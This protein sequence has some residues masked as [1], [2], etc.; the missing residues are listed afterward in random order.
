MADFPEIPDVSQMSPEESSDRFGKAIAIAVVLATLAAALV[1]FLQAGALRTDDEAAVR[2]ERLAAESLGQRIRSQEIAQVQF[3]RFELAEQQRRRAGRARQRRFFGSGDEQALLLEEERLTRVVTQTE[4]SSAAIAKAQ[5]VKPLTDRGETG[6]Q[7][8]PLFP[9][10]YLAGARREGYRL[11]ALRD[12]ANA[13]GDRAEVQ[14]TNY[15][16]SLTM[17]AVAV[18][19][20]GYSLTPQG[21]A[22][23]KLFAGVATGF[24][25]VAAVA[26]AVT[27]S[28]PPNRPPDEAAEA[29]AD[30][31]VAADT[32]DHEAA[33]RHFDRALDLRPDFARA[34]ILR[35]GAI[36][37]GGA[38][39]LTGNTALVDDR[40]LER[41]IDDLRAARD[42]GAE[43]PQALVSLGFDL[44]LEGLREDDDDRIEEGIE[45]LEAARGRFKSNPAVDYNLGL[46]A[47]ALGRR[48]EAQEHYDRAVRRTIFQ[49]ERRKVKRDDILQEQG[50]VGAAFSDLETLS[51]A[52][53][54]ELGDAIAEVKQRIV[55]PVSALTSPPVTGEELAPEQSERAAGP[56]ARLNDIEL[57]VTPALTQM[58]VGSEENFDPTKDRLSLQWYWRPPGGR[59]WSVLNEVSGSALEDELTVDASD[60]TYLLRR[61]FVQLS[62]P[63][64]CLADGSYRLE[65]YV[66]GRLAGQGKTEAEFG[67]QE[68]DPVRDIGVA[69]CRPPDWKPAPGRVPGLVSGSLSP[70]DESGVFVFSID[71]EV[72]GEGEPS[73]ARSARIIAETL[74]RFE[75]ADVGLGRPERTDEPF[76]GLDGELVQLYSLAGG[77]LIAGSGQKPDGEILVGIAFG[78][79]RTADL[80]DQVFQSL[81][82][83]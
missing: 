33:V 11:S 42:L 16:V 15:A 79:G 78:S 22:R 47:L 17:L 66:N 83:I 63:T 77:A 62:A 40:T 12:A 7:E 31:R 51:A 20:F 64:T 71:P 6:P 29:F 37:D 72:A 74:R 34:H 9:E 30:G 55:G 41:T 43:D 70:D 14:F 61:S 50:Y 28:D 75:I 35:A 39:A 49:D 36:T 69:Y 48:D 1:A 67:E 57:V 82:D 73:E 38:P 10:R 58:S 60:N 59:S 27:A 21:R 25:T 24:V 13:E 8:D 4:K 5:G 2:A 32:L 52:R 65:A 3:E 56:P 26:A 80:V 44:T 81:S 53:G 18:F 46:A 76:L 23:R 54:K 68:A 19:L 45:A